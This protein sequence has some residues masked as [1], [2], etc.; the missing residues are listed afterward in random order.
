MAR[1]RPRA[2]LRPA[3]CGNPIAGKDW[4]ELSEREQQVIRRVAMG[5]T[6]REI[7]GRWHRSVKTVET[8]RARA[9]A[10]WGLQSRAQRVEYAMRR[11]PRG[12]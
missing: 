10:K 4:G 2:R 11:G 3:T 8:Y 12:E 1:A 9:M 6:H 7:A 5:F